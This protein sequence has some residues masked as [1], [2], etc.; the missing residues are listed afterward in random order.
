MYPIMGALR[1][2][3]GGKWQVRAWSPG[4]VPNCL[5]ACNTAPGTSHSCPGRRRPLLGQCFDS[6]SILTGLWPAIACTCAGTA[7]SIEHTLPMLQM[8]CAPPAMPAH[9]SVSPFFPQQMPRELAPAVCLCCSCCPAGV[10]VCAWCWP[11][12]P[13]LSTCKLA[14]HLQDLLCL[15]P[16]QVYERVELGPGKEEY[17]HIGSFDQQ[18]T[19]PEITQCFRD[20][21]N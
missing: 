20:S 21:P 7:G 11:L 12:P 3:F 14:Q 16:W 8:R 17:R 2:S 13:S 1:Y 18:P 15:L 19:P 9:K 10:R 4:R 5:C 6:W